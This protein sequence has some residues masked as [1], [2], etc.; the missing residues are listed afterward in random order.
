MR[1][2]YC[3]YGHSKNPPWQAESKKEMYRLLGDLD[4]RQSQLSRRQGE[5]VEILKIL[6]PPRKSN[7]TN[8]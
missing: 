5:I 6:A 8:E 7:E 2:I 3:Y 4:Q 1:H